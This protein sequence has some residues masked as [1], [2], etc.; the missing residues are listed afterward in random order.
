MTDQEAG[1]S[2]VV[3]FAAETS[4]SFTTTGPAAAAAAAAAQLVGTQAIQ[5]QKPYNYSSCQAVIVLCLT[6]YSQES[7]TAATALG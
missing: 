6:M 4:T 1:V 3:S 5:G 7:C 2:L